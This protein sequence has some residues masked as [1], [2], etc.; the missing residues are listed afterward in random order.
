[1]SDQAHLFND[2]IRRLTDI[3]DDM[4]DVKATPDSSAVITFSDGSTARIQSQDCQK[5]FH[6]EETVEKLCSIVRAVG[7]P[8]NETTIELY[9]MTLPEEALFELEEKF[10]VVEEV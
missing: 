7:S 3:L 9:E 10:A 6:S 4:D 5:I 8:L 2:K 1:M